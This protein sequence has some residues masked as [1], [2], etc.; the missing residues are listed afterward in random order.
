M[1]ALQSPPTTCD[2][3]KP[4]PTDKSDANW[5]VKEDVWV[6]GSG[7]LQYSLTG[8]TGST[9]YDVQ[10]RAVNAAGESEW[11]D[12]VTETTDASDRAGSSN[13]VDG[14]GGAPERRG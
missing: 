12:T 11:S 9:G 7:P 8:L 4:E 6:T 3:S 1:E 2:T 10:V 13:R 5:T 14:S